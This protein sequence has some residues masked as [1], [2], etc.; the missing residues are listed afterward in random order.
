MILG[1][2]IV[3]T[4]VAGLKV[5]K[6]DGQHL[7]DGGETVTLTSYWL[8]RK[9]DGDVTLAEIV[10]EQAVVFGSATVLTKE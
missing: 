8:R 4:P 9:N 5:R 1:Q 10:P 6:E 2:P 7:A 3:A